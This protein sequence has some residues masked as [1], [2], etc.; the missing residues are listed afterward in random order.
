VISIAPESEIV[1]ERDQTTPG[2]RAAASPSLVGVD[3]VAA[4]LILS[5]AFMIVAGFTQPQL[6]G[7][8]ASTADRLELGACAGAE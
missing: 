7:Y 1:P 4:F 6:V 3:P 8:G 2:R 5:N